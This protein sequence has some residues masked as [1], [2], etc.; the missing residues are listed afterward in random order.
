MKIKVLYFAWL[1][2]RIGKSFEEIETE[3]STIEELV[4]ELRLKEDSR[5]PC[6][7]HSLVIGEPFFD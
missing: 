1:R 4:E 3:A 6:F 2:E 7:L 5:S